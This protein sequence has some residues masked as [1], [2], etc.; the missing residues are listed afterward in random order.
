MKQL[1]RERQMIQILEAIQAYGNVSQA[2]EA[3]FMTQPTV[4]KIIRNQEKQYGISFLD[5]T[6][7]PLK[8]TYAGEF[9]LD[10][11]RK[12]VADYQ[13]MTH[14]LNNFADNRVGRL[15]IGVNQSLAQVVLPAVLPEFHRRYPQIQ[16]QLSEKTSATMEEE[17]LNQELDLYVA[18]RQPI[19]NAC[20]ISD[21]IPMAVR[22][23]CQN[24]GQSNTYPKNNWT[25][26]TDQRQG[27]RCRN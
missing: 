13:T 7:H 6:E 17:V 1:E 14:D 27:L 21:C 15:T 24:S 11:V 23:C 12:L 8:L 18:L 19:T 5:R 9:Y 16:V 10:R 26:A 4:S 2:A 22:Y 20:T 3:L 25:S